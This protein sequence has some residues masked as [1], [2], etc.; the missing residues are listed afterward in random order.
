VLVPVAAITNAQTPL[1]MTEIFDQTATLAK[2]KT[3]AFE[4]V[5]HVAKE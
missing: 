5:N 1:V 4:L 3:N 2:A